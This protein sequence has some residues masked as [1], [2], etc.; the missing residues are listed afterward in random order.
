[1]EERTRIGFI[2]TH[3]SDD[4]ERATLPFMIAAVAPTMNA[5]PVFV[6]QAEGVHLAVNGFA[7]TVAADGLPAL[8]DLL[9]MQ[10]AAAAQI[11]VCSPCLATRGIAEEDLRDGVFIGGAAKVVEMLKECVNVVTY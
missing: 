4:P 11:M 5:E 10:I 7:G 6:L 8:E 2:V 1:M 3:S 9:A